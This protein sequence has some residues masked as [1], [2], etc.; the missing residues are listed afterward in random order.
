MDG[1]GWESKTFL[2]KIKK[3]LEK[4]ILADFRG[5]EFQEVFFMLQVPMYVKILS[6]SS[7]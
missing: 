5:T 6:I 1:F 7:V 2:F 4:F 3:E